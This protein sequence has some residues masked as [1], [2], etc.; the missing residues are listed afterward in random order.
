VAIA[1]AGAGA[2][3]GRAGIPGR[4][5]EVVR[6]G[7]CIVGGDVCRPADA[8]AAGLAPCLTDER[9]RGGRLGVSILL[10]HLGA[11][12][13]WTVARRSD[14]SFLLTRADDASAGVAFGIGA[15]LPGVGISVGASGHLDLSLAHGTA[16]ELPS[17]AAA[18]SVL[19]SVRRGDDPGVPPTWRFGDAGL[20]LTG[21][22]GADV[23]G[24]VA[25]DREVPGALGLTA[26]GALAIRS[27][28]RRTPL[29]GPG[30]SVADA[31][32]LLSDR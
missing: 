20:E 32:R 25:P 24:K 28:P 14:G 3:A 9:Q 2:A 27:R 18:A 11:S 8:Q 1:L 5:V 23:G 13:S 10:L 4:V 16:W 6:T 17:A 19:A 21:K 12:G 31:R 22:L 30:V 29:L 15:D 26:L 7:L